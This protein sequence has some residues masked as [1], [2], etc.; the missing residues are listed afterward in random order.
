MVG[1]VIEIPLFIL[2]VVETDFT[3]EVVTIQ[4]VQVTTMEVMTEDVQVFLLE[5]IG[6]VVAIEEETEIIEMVINIIL[7]RDTTGNNDITILYEV[8]EQHVYSTGDE[9][10][11]SDDEKDFLLSDDLDDNERDLED[12]ELFLNF[13]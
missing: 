13:K 7:L 12:F 10:G 1:S 11:L 9:E 6:I 2:N 8:F 3:Q 5:K 4:N